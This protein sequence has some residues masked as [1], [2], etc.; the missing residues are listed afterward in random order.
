MGQQTTQRIELGANEGVLLEPRDR[1]GP[2]VAHQG[3]VGGGGH[4]RR[5][6]GQ[7]EDRQHGLVGAQDQS[8]HGHR[9]RRRVVA[10]GDGLRGQRVSGGDDGVDGGQHV[11][12]LLAEENGRIR[13]GHRH[14]RYGVDA[15]ELRHRQQ[16]VATGGGGAGGPAQVGAGPPEGGDRRRGPI[17][18]IGDVD[19][20]DRAPRGRRRLGQRQ[21][22]GRQR[23]PAGGQTPGPPGHRRQEGVVAELDAIGLLRVGD[24][25]GENGHDAGLELGWLVAGR[26]LGR[27]H[28]CQRRQPEVGGGDHAEVGDDGR[29]GRI[30]VPPHEVAGRGQILGRPEHDAE[31]VVEPRLGVAPCAA[32][33]PPR[34]AGRGAEAH[35]HPVGHGGSGAGCAGY[36]GLH[37]SFLAVEGGRGRTGP[38]EVAGRG[39]VDGLGE[40]QVGDRVVPGGDIAEHGIEARPLGARDAQAS[41]HGVPRLRAATGEQRQQ[42]DPVDHVS[43]RHRLHRLIT[44]LIARL[45]WGLDA[46]RHG[47]LGD[48]SVAEAALDA[49]P[50]ESGDRLT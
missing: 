34:G 36:L 9:P 6:L 25:P 21:I 13:M 12:D 35:H 10:G 29:V 30:G 18:E 19:R 45:E 33:W 41:H 50:D 40:E 24:P 27:Q 42:A 20:P 38:I 14:R 48:A 32:A 11:V 22:G 16:R 17:R 44:F 2:V 3:L 49:V 15:H 37:R 46:Q 26:A 8:E 39:L 7:R 1:R 5:R 31:P 4:E 47:E 23:S 28:K 43:R